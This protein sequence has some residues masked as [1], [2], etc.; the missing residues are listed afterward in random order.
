MMKIKD[1]TK[2]ELNNLI[3]DY[4]FEG[5]DFEEMIEI[6]ENCYVKCFSYYDEVFIMDKKRSKLVEVFEDDRLDFSTLNY[7][8]MQ[9]LLDYEKEI[10]KRLITITNEINDMYNNFI[11]YDFDSIVKF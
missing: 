7:E 4:G 3:E 5:K 2:K 10:D 6:F 9:S 8:R 1:F 11:D